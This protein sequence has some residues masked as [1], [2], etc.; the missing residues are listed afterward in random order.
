MIYKKGDGELAFRNHQRALEVAEYLL[1][2]NYIVMLSKE[3]QLIIVN[4]LWA[5][6]ADRSDAVFVRVEDF[7][8][9]HVSIEAYKYLQD[10][11]KQEQKTSEE[12]EEEYDTLEKLFNEQVRKNSKNE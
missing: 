5:P 9:D 11:L 4:F 7:E 8:E 6:Y 3:E 12:W 10:R 2:E 1:E